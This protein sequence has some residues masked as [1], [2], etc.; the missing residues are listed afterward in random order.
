ME[1][2]HLVGMPKFGEHD[3]VFEWL[4]VFSEKLFVFEE[5]LVPLCEKCHLQITNSTKKQPGP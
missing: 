5:E 2:H 4:K 1:V 3:D